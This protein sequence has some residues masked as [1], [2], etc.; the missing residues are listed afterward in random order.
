MPILDS[1]NMEHHIDGTGYGFSATRIA[2]LGA[3]EY[4][5]VGIA[6]DASGSVA[7]FRGEIEACVQQIVKA[8]RRSPRTDNLLLR[9]VTFDDRVQEVHGFRPLS[10]CNPDDYHGS[11]V[12]GGTTALFDAATNVVESVRGT[13]YVR[14]RGQIVELVLTDLGSQVVASTRVAGTCLEHATRLFSG[15]A[16]Q[17][18]LG[19]TWV[20]L[21]PEPGKAHPL[22]VPELDPYRIQD[23]RFDGGVLMVVGAR[24]TDGRYD[25]LVLRFDPACASYDIRTVEDITPTS[26]DFV[27]LDSGVLVFL[28]EHERL[29]VA[30]SAKGS[31]QVKILQDPM[32]GS[33]MTLVRLGGRVGFVRG[34]RIYS[35]GMK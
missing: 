23:A 9:L 18:L 29:E 4:T 10:E 8:C 11:V 17:S 2:D 34:E 25:R 12:I 21:F 22:P 31:P 28:D 26:L 5:L 1:S 15:V 6:T 35:M 32:L 33:D 30:S 14:S 7:D 27:V 16:V 19:A 20:T 24:R 13:I 3:S